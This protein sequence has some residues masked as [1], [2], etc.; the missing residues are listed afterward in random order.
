MVDIDFV[1]NKTTINNHLIKIDVTKTY[2]NQIDDFA[3]SI[4][5]GKLNYHHAEQATE[6][7]GIVEQIYEISKLSSTSVEEK[8]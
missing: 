5:E 2:L 3:N 1:S 8:H 7:I 4:S 6:A